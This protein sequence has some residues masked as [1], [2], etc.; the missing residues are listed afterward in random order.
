[1]N[2]YERHLGDY[3]RDTTHLSL[4]EHG[5]YTLLLDRY[6]AT[7][8]PIPKGL[9]YRIARAQTP[10]EMAAVDAVLAE[11]FVPRDTNGTS[12]YHNRRADEAIAEYLESQEDAD[13][14]RDNET[15]R[16]RRYRARRRE[17]FDKLREIGVIP[18]FNS[19]MEALEAM[20]SRGTSTGQVHGHD[21]PVPV[22]GTA[23]HTPDT[24]LHTPEKQKKRASA[25][26]C[27]V[28]KP[29]G[30]GEQ[31]WN[32]W[33]TLRRAKKAPVTE[34]VLA[35]ARDEA[36]KAGL[37]LESFFAVWCARGSQGLQADWLKPHE[38]T[39][40]VNGKPSASASFHNKRYTGTAESDLPEDLRPKSETM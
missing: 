33:L 20:L 26:A 27:A 32:D 16:K 18:D 29:L 11:F 37:T 15:E 40:T 24:K 35:S 39:T 25:P 31:T 7:E 14:R 21:A 30:V 10:E 36:S 17:I 13:F 19:S 38:R 9:V 23:T 34:T 5:V 1:M 2:Y 6:Y 22:K 28:A 3:A 4:L 12:A 8:K